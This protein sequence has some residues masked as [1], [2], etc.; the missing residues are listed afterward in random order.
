[1]YEREIFLSVIKW[2]S[3]IVSNMPLGGTDEVTFVS[4]KRIVR[5]AVIIATGIT[6]P[7]GNHSCHFHI[8]C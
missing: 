6:L 7:N 3:A 2:S 1:V 8:S 5:K 4:T